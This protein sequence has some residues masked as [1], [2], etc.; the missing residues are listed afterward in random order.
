MFQTKE[1][2]QLFPNILPAVYNLHF[3]CKIIN[4]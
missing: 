1:I 2:Q 4:F 3:H